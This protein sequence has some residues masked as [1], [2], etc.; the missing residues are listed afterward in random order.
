MTCAA[1]QGPW[2]SKNFLDKWSIFT[3]RSLRQIQ[4]K[5]NE[6]IAIQG[7]RSVV[8]LPSQRQDAAFRG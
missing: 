8:K 3:P 1:D 7:F 4:F 2:K 6:S 5:K